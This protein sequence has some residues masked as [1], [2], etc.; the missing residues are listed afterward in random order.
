M[1][2]DQTATG[3]FEGHEPVLHASHDVR[4]ARSI[5]PNHEEALARLDYVTSRQRG[6][7]LLT[8]PAGCGKSALL[9][10]FVDGLRRNQVTSV[11][12][13]A[14]GCTEA[15]LLRECCDELGLGCPRNWPAAALRTALLEAVRGRCETGTP[16]VLLFDHADRGGDGAIRLIERLL[17]TTEDLAGPSIVAASREP[18]PAPLRAVARDY[19]DVRIQLTPLTADETGDLIETLRGGEERYAGVTPE[20]VRLMHSIA[21]GQLR[22]VNRLWRLLQTAAAVEDIDRIDPQM[23]EAIACELPD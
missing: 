12:V 17:H 20:A 22:Q 14:C 4:H 2:R 19:G 16:V 23:I 10:D 3:G 15:E 18:A 13:D 1:N 5:L 7:A 11:V 9:R 21:R 8:G 6:F